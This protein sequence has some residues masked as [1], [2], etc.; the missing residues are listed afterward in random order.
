MFNKISLL[1]AVLLVS[2]LAGL[3]AQESEPEEGP[4]TP[5]IRTNQRSMGDQTFAI[6]AGVL[7]PLPTYLLNDWPIAGYEKGA[8]AS[9]LSVGGVGSLAYSFY[10]SGN[11][12]MGLQVTGAFTREINRNYAYMIPIV[13]KTSWEFHPWNRVTIPVHLGAGLVMT[14]YKDFFVIDPILRPGFGVYF[15]WSYEWSF[16]MDTSYWFIPQIGA[17]NKSER[18]IGQFMDLTLTAEYHF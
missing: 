9:N 7:F 13:I 4:F 15:D 2:G 1:L 6:T 14:S 5:Q 8:I 17:S 18:S 10:L 11:L 3:G 12:K 16:G